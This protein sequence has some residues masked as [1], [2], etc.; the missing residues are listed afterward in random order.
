MMGEQIL[1]TSVMITNDDDCNLWLMHE[2]RL[3]NRDYTMYYFRSEFSDGSGSAID[4][5][6]ICSLLIYN[7]STKVGEL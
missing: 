4:V 1:S 6:N 2:V 5:R 3:V 7:N